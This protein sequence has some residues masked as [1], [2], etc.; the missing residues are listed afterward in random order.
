MPLVVMH[1]QLS[2]FGQTWVRLAIA[3][4]NWPLQAITSPDLISLGTRLSLSQQIR[5]EV[6]KTT[7]DG[8]LQF[9]DYYLIKGQP[10]NAY[11]GYKYARRYLGNR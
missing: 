10:I 2:P 11:Y 1:R 4:L 7:S 8:P 5:E 9:G 6:I 3:D